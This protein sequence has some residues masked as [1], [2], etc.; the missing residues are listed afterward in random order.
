VVEVTFLTL[1]GGLVTPPTQ[2]QSQYKG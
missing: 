2:Q 1:V